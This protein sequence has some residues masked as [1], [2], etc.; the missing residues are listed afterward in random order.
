MDCWPTSKFGYEHGYKQLASPISLQVQWL[1]VG[2]ERASPRQVD[3]WLG[4]GLNRRDVQTSSF[5]RF[6]ET[7]LLDAPEDSGT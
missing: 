7:S 5:Q 6:F 3:V 4:V 1:G 2:P